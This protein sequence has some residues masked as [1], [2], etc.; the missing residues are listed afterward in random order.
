MYKQASHR[1]LKNRALKRRVTSHH[2]TPKRERCGENNEFAQ[3]RANQTA[4]NKLKHKPE[5]VLQV[6]R[7]LDDKQQATP[8]DPHL[9]RWRKLLDSLIEGQCSIEYITE[10]VMGYDEKAKQLRESAVLH[11]LLD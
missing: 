6:I 3:L 10:E 9:K 11:C 1:S 4:L 7:N 8:E 5:L 2:Y